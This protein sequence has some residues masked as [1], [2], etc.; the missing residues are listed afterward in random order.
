M[1]LTLLILDTCREVSFNR[2]HLIGGGDDP[3]CP[4]NQSQLDRTAACRAG[5]RRPDPC[6]TGLSSNWGMTGHYPRRGW[7]ALPVVLAAVFSLEEI[8]GIPRTAAPFPG[9][10]KRTACV[11]KA[12]STAARAQVQAFAGRAG[13]IPCTAMFTKMQ[14]YWSAEGF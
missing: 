7:V 11:L 9:V 12:P 13:G 3:L 2:G 10:H 1:S 8:A 5:A 14:P 4:K 6:K